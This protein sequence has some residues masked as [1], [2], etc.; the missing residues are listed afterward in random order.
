MNLT[1]FEVQ[2]KE[3]AMFTLKVWLWDLWSY[4]LPQKCVTRSQE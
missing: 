4:I 1:T 2:A 3:F